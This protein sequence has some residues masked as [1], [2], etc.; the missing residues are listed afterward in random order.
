MNTPATLAAA[1][2]ITPDA[3]RIALTDLGPDAPYRTDRAF[4]LREAAFLREKYSARLNGQAAKLQGVPTE[5]EEK[6]AGLEKKLR[7]TET[8][9]AETAAKLAALEKAGGESGRKADATAAKLHETAAKLASAET[10]AAEAAA[11]LREAVVKNA[12]TAAKLRETENM[13]V[14]I[15]AKLAVAETARAE[16]AAKLA[17]VAVKADEADRLASV[18]HRTEGERREL[19]ATVAAKD[20]EISH[21]LTRMDA[22]ETASAEHAAERWQRVA[23]RVILALRASIVLAH[24]ALWAYGLHTL[25]GEAGLYLGAIVA[26]FVA[27]GLVSVLN[28]RNADTSSVFMFALVLLCLGGCWLDTNTFSTF[29]REEGREMAGNPGAVAFGLAIFAGMVTL[30]SAGMNRTTVTD[31]DEG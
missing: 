7:E 28:P 15:A 11:N 19:V 21:Y 20:A 10:I 23:G 12:E 24:A 5:T 27:L 17:T 1:L 16:T 8:A 29:F 22:L 3:I 31:N 9:R 2:G 30:A 14:E 4:S 18:L 6:L 25:A 13:R 26:G